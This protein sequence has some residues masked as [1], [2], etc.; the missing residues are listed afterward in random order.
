VSERRTVIDST[1]DEP[2]VRRVARDPSSWSS[3][4]TGPVQP[5]APIAGSGAARSHFCGP[6]FGAAFVLDVTRAASSTRPRDQC[7][8]AVFSRPPGEGGAAWTCGC[9]GVGFVAVLLAGMMTFVIV[10]ND[11]RVSLSR[12]QGDDLDTAAAVRGESQRGQGDS[13]GA[14]GDHAGE[15]TTAGGDAHSATSTDA[16]GHPQSADHTAAYIELTRAS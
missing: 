16:D 3:P 2:A 9:W 10:T 13:P 4:V 5:G 14:A 15:H 7:D 6:S 11:E 8:F 12:D 1:R